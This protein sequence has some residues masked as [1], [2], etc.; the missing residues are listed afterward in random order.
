M[1]RWWRGQRFLRGVVLTGLLLV[2]L[3]QIKSSQNEKG[4]LASGVLV[5]D[6]N[7]RRLF[8]DV[9]YE[10][11]VDVWKLPQKDKR[12][13][14]KIK[15]MIQKP[16]QGDYN[17]TNPDFTD[18]SRG[19][20]TQIDNILQGKVSV[21]IYSLGIGLHVSQ[22]ML[23]RRSLKTQFF[24]L[25]NSFCLSDLEN[26]ADFAFFFISILECIKIEHH[27]KDFGECEI[28]LPRFKDA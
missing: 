11:T 3:I 27:K 15:W 22:I 10:T 24:L 23:A 28:N 25:P 16:E 6:A 8:G 2:V 26:T 4:Y 9:S 17:L 19:Q 14:S 1:R 7:G 21:W 18:F 12:L 20:S 13:L 5:H